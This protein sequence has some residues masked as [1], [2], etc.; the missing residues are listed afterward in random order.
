MEE[1]SLDMFRL[2]ENLEN[3]STEWEKEPEQA[4]NPVDGSNWIHKGQID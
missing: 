3:M 2:K 4:W 1:L